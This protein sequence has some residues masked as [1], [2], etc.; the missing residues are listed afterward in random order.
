MTGPEPS[1]RR[2]QVE[3]DLV[4]ADLD[5]AF[6]LLYFAETQSI[7]GSHNEAYR[8]LEEADAACSDGQ[9]RLH[10]L[11]L[12]EDRRVSAQLQ[13]MRDLIDGMKSR[14]KAA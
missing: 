3:R 9:H 10:V 5:T 2:S 12:E 6:A 4:E 13:R 1:R 7:A 11:G 14:L 8:A